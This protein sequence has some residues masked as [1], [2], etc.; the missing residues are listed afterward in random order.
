VKTD[1][2]FLAE[3]EA[4]PV[5][6]WDFS[7]FE[8]RATEE[9][10]SWGYS[11]PLPARI[12]ALKPL[13]QGLKPLSRG[14]A[15][16]GMSTPSAERLRRGDEALPPEGLRARLRL[17]GFAAVLDVQTGGGEVYAEALNAAERRPDVVVATEAWPPNAALARDRIPGAVVLTDGLPF[18]DDTFDLVLSRHPIDTDWTGI[19]RILRAGGTYLSQQVGAGSMREL[20]DALM[21]PQPVNDYRAPQRHAALAEAA[22][23]TVVRLQSES[24]RTEFLDLAAVVHYLR[25]VIWIVP[26]FTVDAYRQRL[27]ALPIPFVAYSQRFLIEARKEK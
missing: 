24:L 3:G 2:D 23:L 19:A 7:W 4:D 21:G 22:G 17:N 12:A 18:P 13:S 10:P 11:R 14:P 16:P 27:K 15:A 9:R 20:T 8:G 1:D 26:G 5:D 25:K 6:G